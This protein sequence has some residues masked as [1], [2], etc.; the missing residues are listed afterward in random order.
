M[1][2]LGS[3]ALTSRQ[4]WPH[5]RE[6]SRKI[7]HIGTG[8]VVPLAWLFAIPSMIA[9]PFAAVITLVTAINHQWQLIPAIEDIDRKSYGTIAYG[10]A[11]TI[12]LILFWPHRADAVCVGVLVMALG[13]G[14]A[15]LIGQQLNTPRWTIFQQTKSIAGTSTMA[16]V[17][18]LVLFALSNFTNSYLSVPV[19]IAIVL[20]AT[21]L[22][23]LSIRGI[24]NLS[25]PLAVGLAWSA[26]IH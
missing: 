3:L 24:D 1:V 2:C 15:G 6:L 26:L 7:I 18:A 19:A 20:T 17:S 23:Q 21:G 11:I 13:D 12:L 14:L 25:V 22:E 5:K 10:L 16:I 8:A 9:I 4:R